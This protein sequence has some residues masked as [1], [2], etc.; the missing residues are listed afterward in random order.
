MSSKHTGQLDLDTFSTHCNKSKN[1][2]ISISGNKTRSFYLLCVHLSSAATADT[3]CTLD[4]GKIFR[5]HLLDIYHKG[6][7]GIAIYLRRQINCK[8]N[9]YTTHTHTHT[10][11]T[12]TDKEFWLIRHASKLVTKRSH[13]PESDTA[14]GIGT[15]RLYFLS[16]ITFRTNEFRHCLPI[17]IMVFVFVVTVSA[18]VYFFAAWGLWKKKH[19][20]KTTKKSYF[21]LETLTTNFARLL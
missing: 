16:R 2:F 4:N 11:R 1:R 21:S 19:D 5:V 15:I 7:N 13:L 17:E 6:N 9:T 18:R 8:L 12:Y 10:H 3:C 20:I 14:L